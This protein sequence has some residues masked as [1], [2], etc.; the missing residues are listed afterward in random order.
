MGRRRHGSTPAS[1][2]AKRRRSVS[3]RQVRFIIPLGSALVERRR[4]WKRFFARNGSSAQGTPKPQTP[5][6]RWAK[7]MAGQHGIRVV[8]LDKGG[9]GA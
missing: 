6:K 5:L 8:S 3:V 9:L 2:Q 1:E 4:M 7:P